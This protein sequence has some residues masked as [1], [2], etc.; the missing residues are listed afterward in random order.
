ML[1]IYP[2]LNQKERIQFTGMIMG[3]V[4]MCLF[5]DNKNVDSYNNYD[6]EKMINFLRIPFV[7]IIIKSNNEINKISKY[8][9]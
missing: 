3:L 9:N 7:T 8:I 4:E 5:H 6:K 2:F 1:D